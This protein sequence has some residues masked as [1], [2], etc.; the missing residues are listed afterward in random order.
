MRVCRQPGS[1]CV[2]GMFIIPVAGVVVL[3]MQVM[4]QKDCVVR[5]LAQKLL[6]LSHVVGHVDEV[7]L[8]PFSEPLMPALIVVKKKNSDRMAFSINSP[9]TKFREQ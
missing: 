7:T 5:V 1:D 2:A 6:C 8:E 9:D 4:I 3:G